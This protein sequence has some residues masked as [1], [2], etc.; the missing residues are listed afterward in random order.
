MNV[1]VVSKRCR[2]IDLYHS[3]LMNSIKAYFDKS[4]SEQTVFLFV[5]YI[6]TPVLAELIRNI[7]GRIVI[8]T[9]WEPNDILSGSSD[10]ELYPFC[11]ERK[12][13]LYISKGLHLKVYS[14]DL[15]SCILATGNISHNG[16]LPDGNYEMA[17]LIQHMTIDNR[18][19]LA[20][21][22]HE[23]RLV[24]DMMYQDLLVWYEKNKMNYE[25]IISFQDIVSEPPNTNFS[26]ASLP[27]TRSIDDLVSG[28]IRISQG[29]EPS[30]DAETTACILHDLVNYGIFTRLSE[31]V[32]V[33]ELTRRFFE[34]PFINK[35]D[36]FINP[37]A[38]FGSIKAWIQDN[39]VDVPVPSRRELTGNVQVLLEWFVMLG[40]GKYVVDIPGRHS[41]RIKKLYH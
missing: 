16:L 5:P 39:C 37:E 15:T 20:G 19:F 12:I 10:L 31:E 23:S 6:K 32:F 3:P 41:Q 24:D 13:P 11:N 7:K 1:L 18:L 27:M 9:T 40:K 29:L 38:Y 22:Q 2:R 8:V 14:I 35:I 30:D 25:K 4:T 21:I 17:T 28:Y 36:A 26:V 33:V 34:H